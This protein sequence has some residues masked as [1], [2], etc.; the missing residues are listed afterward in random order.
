MKLRERLRESE[1][2]KVF[3]KSN[4][5]YG[6]LV[7][8]F[9]SDLVSNKVGFVASKKVGGSVQRNRARRLMR[10]A[11]LRMQ[12][13]LPKERSYILVARAS[14]NN[15]KMDEVLRDIKFIL[16]KEVIEK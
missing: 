5:Y 10:E 13:V 7:V 16:R 1:F 6:T 3:D 15:K 14:I 2:K 9:V 8:V 11:F 4:K 12:P